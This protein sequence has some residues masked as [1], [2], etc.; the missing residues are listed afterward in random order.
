MRVT[1]TAD[2]MLEPILDTN[3]DAGTSRD[4]IGLGHAA[5][6][7]LNTR[8]GTILTLEDISVSSMVSRPSTTS[9]CT[10]VSASCAASSAPMAP[11]RPP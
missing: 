2:F 7:G 11:A 10:S 3:K 5:G 4:A 6:K 1:A 8:H 9:T